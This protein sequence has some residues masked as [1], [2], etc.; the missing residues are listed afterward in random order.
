MF[1]LGGEVKAKCKFSLPAPNLMLLVMK[2]ENVCK[3]YEPFF[4]G[5]RFLL[6]NDNTPSLSVFLR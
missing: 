1:F 3:E 5:F 4:F 2:K 6:N